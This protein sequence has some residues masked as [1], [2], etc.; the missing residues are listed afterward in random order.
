MLLHSW[1]LRTREPIPEKSTELAYN[2]WAETGCRIAS[3]GACQASVKDSSECILVGRDPRKD[4][5]EITSYWPYYSNMFC[6]IRELDWFSINFD[7]IDSLPVFNR[8][9]HI[10]LVVNLQLGLVWTE[11]IVWT[12]SGWSRDFEKI[13]L[14][15]FESLLPFPT[16][17]EWKIEASVR[18]R[19]L[20]CNSPSSVLQHT[21]QFPVFNNVNKPNLTKVIFYIT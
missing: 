6:S 13:S 14:S 12:D 8:V 1:S 20:C 3:M 10:L 9:L 21:I 19:I 18:S 11:I 16:K 7:W 2:C 4:W 17:A 5:R 15:R